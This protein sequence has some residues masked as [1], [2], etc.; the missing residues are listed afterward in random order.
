MVNCVLATDIFDKDFCAL[1]KERWSK[2]F[3][4]AGSNSLALEDIDR[5]ATIV[6]EH[7][8]Q[9]SDVSHTMQH[10]HIYKKWNERL[11]EELYQAYLDGRQE[12][13]PSEGWYKGEIWF[14]DNYIIPLAYKLKECGVF[15]A[16]GDEYHSYAIKNRNEWADRGEELCREMLENTEQKFATDGRYFM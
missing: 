15:G 1:R 5:K 11:F 14:F 12:K 2:A 3:A 16:S 4:E 8:I 9:A 7:I 13:D 6:I 10:W